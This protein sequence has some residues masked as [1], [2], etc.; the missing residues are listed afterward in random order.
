MVRCSLPVARVRQH[1][2][3]MSW[4]RKVLVVLVVLAVS[5]GCGGATSDATKRTQSHTPTPTPSTASSIFDAP[6]IGGSF[7]VGP[8]RTRL[9]IR[10]WGSGS[11]VIIIEGGSGEGGLGRW[12][13]NPVTEALAKHTE[14]C[15]YDR[16]G[17]GES[18]QAPNRARG[19]DDVVADLHALLREAG[20]RSPYLMAGVSG[21][22]GYAFHYAGRYPAQVAGLVMIETPVGQAKMSAK[23]VK[24][25]AWDAPGN[26][27]H[28]EYVE[29]EH[30][31]AAARL[32]IGPIPVT[33]VTGRSG[34][35]AGDLRSQRVWLKGSS[36]P[37]Q[38]ILETG[39]EVDVDDPAGL[40]REMLATLEAAQHR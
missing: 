35:S 10:C 29:V 28:V 25:L 37:R 18:G 26:N 15:A 13:R 36:L 17:T 19:L 39:H 12:E 34:Q 9:A 20:V 4:R 24:E 40:T 23:D 11:P 1:N 6:V 21:G 5:A 31:M 16:A 2:E 14:V 22:G 32:P 7:A 30:Q 8:D 33:V 38:V 27:E 3:K